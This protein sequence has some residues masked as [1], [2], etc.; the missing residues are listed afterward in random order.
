MISTNTHGSAFRFGATPDFIV[1]IHLVTGPSKHVYL[2]RAS[3]PVIQD[4]FADMLGAELV[5]DDAMFNAALVSFGLFGII[6]GLMMEARELFLLHAFRSFHPFNDGLRSAISSLDFSG[7]DLHGQSANRLYHF[8]VTLNPNEGNPP[9]EATVY[10]MFE[11]PWRDDYQPP[12]WDDAASGP[13]ASGLEVIA[14]LLRFD[15]Q[16]VGQSGS[17]VAQSAGQESPGAV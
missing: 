14:A 1:G 16:T 3:Y 2:E 9:N 4:S 12:Q 11:A 7:I 5:R 17:S 6:H 15:P 8:Q 10:T 13:G